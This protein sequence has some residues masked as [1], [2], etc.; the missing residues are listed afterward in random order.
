MIT[1]SPILI[2]G[3]PRSGASMIA[4]TI[5]MCGAFGGTMVGGNQNAKRG[6]FENVR[7]RE[8]LVKTY[9]SDCGLDVMG[10]YPLTDRKNYLYFPDG[11]KEKVEN[12]LLSEGYKKGPWLYK[13]ARSALIWPIWSMNY[14]DAKWVIVRRRTGDVIDSCIKTG[15]MKAF[16][17]EVNQQAVGAKNEREGWLWWV[18]EYEKKIVR[19]ISSGLNC[20]VIWPERM[21]DG[22]YRQLY[23][24]CDWLG[25]TWKEEALIY[26]NTLL[27]NSR[28]KRKGEQNGNKN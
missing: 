28:L 9:L 18:H 17:N 6:M 4:A 25:L 5:N 22:D 16:K 27:W 23:E 11:W 13:D 2:T 12:I 21:V 20:K 1:H 8:D 26:I 7:I 19:M 24:L 15:F 3:C 10:Q 14:P